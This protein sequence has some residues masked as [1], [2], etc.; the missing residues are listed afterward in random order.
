MSTSNIANTKKQ[1]NRYSDYTMYNELLRLSRMHK[2]NQFAFKY[3]TTY[4]AKGYPVILDEIES[5]D[6]PEIEDNKKELITKK[7]L[8]VLKSY[9]NQYCDERS[10]KIET[11]YI[12]GWEQLAG[13][14]ET[15]QFKTFVSTYLP[16]YAGTGNLINS[17]KIEALQKSEFKND[18]KKEIAY[19]LM[20]ELFLAKN[21]Y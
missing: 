12:P 3:L 4:T 19:S 14:I 2:F 6:N 13:Y 5:L 1:Y 18:E 15:F 9:K 11:K 21:L 10:I 8:I 16:I 7:M 20:V 17:S